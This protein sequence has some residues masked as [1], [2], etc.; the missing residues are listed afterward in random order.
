MY[1]VKQGDGAARYYQNLEDMIGYRPCIWWKICW[2]FLTP[3][4]CFGVFVF[5]LVQYRPL[6]YIDYV[7][8][9]WGQLVGWFLALSTMLCIPGYAIYKFIVT[10]GDLRT[11]CKELFRPD[12][13]ISAEIRARKHRESGTA[14]TAV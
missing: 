1:R 13:D 5:S 3:C 7:Y 14:A 10:P 12:I 11:R 8:P 6:T 9:W 2:V 4:V